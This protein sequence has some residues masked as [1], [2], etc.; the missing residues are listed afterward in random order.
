MQNSSLLLVIPGSSLCGRSGRELF[1][2]SGGTVVLPKLTTHTTYQSTR[3]IT[4]YRRLPSITV[5]LIQ[6]GFLIKINA[7][8]G[9]LVFSP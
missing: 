9:V 3:K 8:W 1:G 2:L 5:F 7:R 4:P 6:T